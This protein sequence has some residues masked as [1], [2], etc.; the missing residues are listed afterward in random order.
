MI[1][2]AADENFH[3]LIK[4]GPVVVDFFS[5]TCVPC[6]MI[7]RV[8]EEIDEEF[9]FVNVVKVDVEDCPETAK[10]YEV[11]GIPDLYFYKD[12]EVVRHEL[13]AI[14]AGDLKECIAEILY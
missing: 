5:K 12:N 6:K 3:D 11:M 10:E 7:A 14:P 1:T 2:Y 9:P 8:L 4:E 13:G